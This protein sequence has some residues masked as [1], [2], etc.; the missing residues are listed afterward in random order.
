MPR[1]S[2]CDN[3]DATAELLSSKEASICEDC[4][5]EGLHRLKGI[6]HLKNLDRHADNLGGSTQEDTTIPIVQIEKSQRWGEELSFIA[7]GR[8]PEQG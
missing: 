4:L 2:F 5:V 1:C 7:K 8:T 6:A 3:T